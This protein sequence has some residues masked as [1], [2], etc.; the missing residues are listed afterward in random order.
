MSYVVIP[1][2]H[3]DGEVQKEQLNIL[4]TPRKTPIPMAMMIV[5]ALRHHDNHYS[6][7]YFL[8]ILYII[9]LIVCVCISLFVQF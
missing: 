6:C 1:D 5:V 3:F 7:C 8:L 9:G 2:D 4:L